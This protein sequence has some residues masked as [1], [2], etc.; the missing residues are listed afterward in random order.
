MERRFPTL[1]EFINEQRLVEAGGQDAGKLELVQT[2]LSQAVEY[3]EDTMQMDLYKE[4]PDFDKN[5]TFAQNKAK[6]GWTQRKDMPVITDKDVKDLQTRLSNGHVDVRKPFKEDPRTDPFP[7]G[8]TGEMAEEWL[9]HGLEDGQEK[10]DKVKVQQKTFKVGELKP[11]QQQIYFD[12]AIEGIAKFGAASSQK[13]FQS[14]FFIASNDGYILD[15]HHRFLG[16]VLIDP[17]MKVKVLTIDL[18][19]D[20]LLPMT[21]AYGDAI[22]NERNQ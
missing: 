7:E 8:L 18:P 10:D 12:K 5:Y 19:I 21:K 22:G 20:T 16:A 14:T 17:D 3:A 6:I 4:I 11:I 15:G 13:F 9:K 2:K 1:D